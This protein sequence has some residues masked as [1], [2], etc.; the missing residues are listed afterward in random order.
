MRWNC[1]QDYI[2]SQDSPVTEIRF[3]DMP[4]EDALALKWSLGQQ[5]YGPV[6][7]GD[8]LE[9]LFEELLDG[10][11]YAEKLKRDGAPNMEPYIT[12]LT[13]MALDLQTR[14]RELR[15]RI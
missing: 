11:H 4:Y 2:Y 7:V 12:T 8:P 1:Q 6:F 15:R 3:I 5:K 14:A 9:H 10:R 13:N